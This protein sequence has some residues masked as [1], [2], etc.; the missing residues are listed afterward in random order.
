MEM[1]ITDK[2]YYCCDCIHYLHGQ[3]EQP[4]A[5]GCAYVGYLNKGCHKW[6]NEK[7]EKMPVITHKICIECGRTLSI[8]NFSRQRD[9]E[10]RLSRRCKECNANRK[11]KDC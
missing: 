2:N 5:K 9:T 11:K 10:D 8:K 1:G 7:G 6:Q 3:L 4:C